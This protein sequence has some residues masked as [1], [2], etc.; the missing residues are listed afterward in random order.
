[1]AHIKISTTVETVDT[2]G[3]KKTRNFIYSNTSVNEVHETVIDVAASTT[4]VVWDPVNWTD[5]PVSAFDTLVI[6]AD[7]EIDLEFTVNEGNASENLFSIRLQ[8][9]L[10]LSVGSNDSYYG[11][12]GGSLFAGTLDVIDK[13]RA[14]EP[15]GESV[16]LTLILVD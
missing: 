6:F 14:K 8:A 3:S 11:E 10:P 4:V 7:K 9:D 12:S 5:Y 1:M 15:N 13:I 16:K 2:L